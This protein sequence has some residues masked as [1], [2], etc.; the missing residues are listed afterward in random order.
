M[1]TPADDQS[2]AMIPP[3]VANGSQPRPEFRVY[4]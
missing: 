1:I 4:G 2:P 3:D